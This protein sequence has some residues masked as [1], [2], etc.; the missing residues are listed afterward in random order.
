[1]EGSYYRELI[2]AIKASLPDMHIHAFSPFEVWYGSVKSKMSYRDF[3]SDLKDCGLG[4]HAGNSG[5]NTRY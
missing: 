5:R 1:M 3:L 4:I 2:L